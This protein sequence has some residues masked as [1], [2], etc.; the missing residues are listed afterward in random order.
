MN[1][2]PN[3]NNWLVNIDAIALET[4]KLEAKK[5]ILQNI[6]D[7]ALLFQRIQEASNMDEFNRIVSED[8]E[9]TNDSVF[10]EAPKTTKAAN[11]PSFK[12]PEPV[13]ITLEDDTMNDIENSTPISEGEDETETKTEETIEN[14][15]KVAPTKYDDNFPIPP[16]I[17]LNLGWFGKAAN[18]WNDDEEQKAA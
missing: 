11:E 7:F 14:E 6:Q 8:S 16:K 3:L 18:S 12:I 9:A 15:E 4:K 2:T 10:N 1:A 5:E 17:K 13:N